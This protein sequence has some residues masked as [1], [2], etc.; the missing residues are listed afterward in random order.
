[1][2]VHHVGMYVGPRENMERKK[3][4]TWISFPPFLVTRS[5]H[6][7]GKSVHYK[8]DFCGGKKVL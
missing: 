2:L 6:H 5:Y 4:L 8:S 1:M 7:M 3:G